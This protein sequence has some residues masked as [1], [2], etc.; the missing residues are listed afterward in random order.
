MHATARV[1][2]VIAGD[3]ANTVEHVFVDG[4]EVRWTV[5]RVGQA[6][7]AEIA[8]TDAS[9]AAFVRGVLAARREVTGG[10]RARSRSGS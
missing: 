10:G 4:D 7:D 9:V 6:A 3:E 5:R 2:A 8:V 1:T